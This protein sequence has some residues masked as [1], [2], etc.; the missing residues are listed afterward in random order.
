MR[1]SFKINVQQVA[2]SAQRQETKDENDS[3]AT[4]EKA[5]KACLIL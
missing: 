4:R 1:T 3:L 5:R 2:F